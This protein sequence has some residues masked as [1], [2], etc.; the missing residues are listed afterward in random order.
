[1]NGSG[2]G[3]GDN[4]RVH[5]FALH[6]FFDQQCLEVA[7]HF[8][9]GRANHCI[10]V[11]QI[12]HLPHVLAVGVRIVAAC[13]GTNIVNG[14]VIFF[15]E[16]GTRCAVQ[17]PIAVL[18]HVQILV[19]EIGGAHPKMPGNAFHIYITKN[20]GSSFAAIRTLQAIDVLKNFFVLFMKQLVEVLSLSQPTDKLLILLL[21]L[22]CNVK[23]FLVWI[24]THDGRIRWNNAVL[25]R[26]AEI[27]ILHE[28]RVA[29]TL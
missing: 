13:P 17:H 9:N 19:C 1:M 29:Q 28:F 26:I 14:A 20:R 27:R 22:I 25:M 12:Q 2:D 11:H 5:L 10:A 18:I 16:E 15:I 6:G 24:F 3:T 8:G 21:L 23:E 7:Y 4:S